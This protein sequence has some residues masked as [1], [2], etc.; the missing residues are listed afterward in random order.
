MHM[1][2][3]SFCR[4]IN[5]ATGEQFAVK[6]LSISH[7]VHFPHLLENEYNGL[8]LA[9]NFKIPRVVKLEELI[10]LPNGD[11]LVVLE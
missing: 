4:W 7:H 10:A 8:T 3:L 6:R 5:T 9:N 2:G 11:G 1:T